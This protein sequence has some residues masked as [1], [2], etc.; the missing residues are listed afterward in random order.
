MNDVVTIPHAAGKC[1]VCGC[2]ELRPCMSE[3][4]DGNPVQ[5]CSWFDLEETLCTNLPCIG[6]TP[7]ETL[8][9]MTREMRAFKT[10]I[11]IGTA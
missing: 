6:A 3:G 1:R 5:F 8:L 9:K 10:F 2:S 11:E 4:G 7:L